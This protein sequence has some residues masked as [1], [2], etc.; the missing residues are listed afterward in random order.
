MLRIH[1]HYHLF[2]KTWVFTCFYFFN[3]NSLKVLLTPHKSWKYVY[4]SV[5]LIEIPI[6][7]PRKAWWRPLPAANQVAYPAA[8]VK[9]MCPVEW[10]LGGAQCSN[11]ALRPYRLFRWQSTD[12]GR[13]EGL[14]GSRRWS[15][16]RP[17][18]RHGASCHCAT[19]VPEQ[20]RT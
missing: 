5:F 6:S 8:V 12:P 20:A 18:E 16:H 11:S 19:H 7:P 2:S 3:K 10:L 9:T 4:R 14:V 15:N 17:C 1:C 13:V